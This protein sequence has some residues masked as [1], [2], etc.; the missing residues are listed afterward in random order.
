LIKNNNTQNIRAFPLLGEIPILGALFRSSNFRTEKSELLFVIT[1]R[2]VKPL[3]ADYKLPTDNFIPPNR[4]EFFLGGKMEGAHR[5]APA[6]TN[7]PAPAATA[8]APSGFE[9]K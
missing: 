9:V 4:A 6:D 2:L 1:P 7:Q 3:P 5:S 8:A